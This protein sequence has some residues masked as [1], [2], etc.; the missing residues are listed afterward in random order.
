MTTVATVAVRTADGLIHA[1]PKPARHHNVLHKL[2]YVYPKA[3]VEQGFIS[4]DGEYL[5]RVDAARI[6]IAAGQTKQLN[7]PP[8][9]FSE[10][11]W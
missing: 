4:S 8:N 10:D 2:H 11:L 7:W 6:A 3:T 1:M 9:L 5:N